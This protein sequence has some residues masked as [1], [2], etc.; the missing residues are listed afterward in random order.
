MTYSIR[1][2]IASAN[3]NPVKA[4]APL[5]PN[6]IASARKHQRNLETTVSTNN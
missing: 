2:R 4:I 5:S 6:A 3:Q 1:N